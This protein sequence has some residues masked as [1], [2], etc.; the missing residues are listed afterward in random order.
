MFGVKDGDWAGAFSE[1]PDYETL[2]AFGPCCGI[3]DLGAVIKADQVCDLLGLDTISAGVSISFAMECLERGIISAEEHDIGDLRFGNAAAMINLLKDIGYQR[4]FGKVVGLGSKTMSERFGQDSAE[5]AMH[6]K[7]MELGGYDPRGAKGMSLVFACGPRGGCHHSG[8][9]TV[10]P[11]LMNP[12]IDR[13]AEDGRA[14]LVA[15]TRNKRAALCDSGL[16]CAFVAI[17]FS[18]ETGAALLS[19]VTG[20]EFQ[21]GDVIAMGDRISCLERAYN[22]REGLTRDQDT[23]PGRLLKEIINRGPSEGHLVQDL[24]AMKDE[25]YKISGWDIETGA[26]LPDKLNQ[27]EIGWVGELMA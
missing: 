26:P 20:I 7:G 24:E 5:F 2:Y 12:Q 15:I 22:Y 27:L 17:A 4:G 11:E 9:Y 6:A 1:G 16:T 14:G 19:A 13:F 10:I 3:F 21:P 25:F 23:L 8:G 18:D